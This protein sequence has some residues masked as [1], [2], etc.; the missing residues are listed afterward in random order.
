MKCKKLARERDNYNNTKY[1]DLWVTVRGLIRRAHPT[2]TGLLWS[3]RLGDG[4]VTVASPRY[5]E[6]VRGDILQ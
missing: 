1:P 3:L 6:A 4:G 5:Q 2:L